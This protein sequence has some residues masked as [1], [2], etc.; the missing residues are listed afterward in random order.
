MGE[1]HMDVVAQ[2]NPGRGPVKKKGTIFQTAWQTNRFRA[3]ARPDLDIT[4]YS[5]RVL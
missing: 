4:T 5:N 1:W 2:Q 3:T